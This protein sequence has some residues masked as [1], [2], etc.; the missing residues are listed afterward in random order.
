V[1]QDVLTDELTLGVAVG[2]L[3]GK[4]IGVFGAAYLAIKLQWT[5]MPMGASTLQLFGVPLLC[6]IGFTMSLFIGLL[7]FVGNTS[8]QEEMKI[9][10]LAGSLGA[11]FLGYLALRFAPREIPPP[12]SKV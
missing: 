2:L 5:D 1:P 12:Q 7:A 3:L 8:M 11:C 4:L 10:I 9:G 6:G